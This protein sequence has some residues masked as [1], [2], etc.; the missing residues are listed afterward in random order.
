MNYAFS[1][2][3]E[4]LSVGES[5]KTILFTPNQSVEGSLT[6]IRAGVYHFTLPAEKSTL[7]P[8]LASRPLGRFCEI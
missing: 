1:S 2:D 3:I 4:A 5:Q 7:A 6:M 8:S